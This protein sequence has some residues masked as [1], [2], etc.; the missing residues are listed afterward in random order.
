VG[1]A[2]IL[3]YAPGV[4][5]ETLTD[6]LAL[7]YQSNP[8]LL[9]QRA[10]L[11][12]TNENYVQAEAGF[13]PN[14][15]VQAT[16]TYNKAPFPQFPTAG[17]IEANYGTGVFSINQPIYT[18]GRVTAQVDTATAQIDAGREQL[19]ATE[20]TV[21]LAVIQAYCD[22]VRDR[23]SLA[24]QEKSFQSLL[25]TTLEIRAR[26][27]AGANTVTDRDQATTQL[28]S[29]KAMVDSARA[30]LESSVAEY[31][32]AVGQPPGTLALPKALLDVPL[33]IDSA[34]DAA[35][36]ESPTLRQAQYAEATSRAQLREAEAARRP[37]VTLSGT[38]GDEGPLS[39]VRTRDYFEDVGVTATLTQPVFT[40]GQIGSQVRQAEAQ[41]NAARIQVE[42]ARRNVMQAVAQAWAQRTATRANVLSAAAE[43]RAA[44]ATYDGM[45]VEYRAGLRITL[46]VLT[47]QETLRDSQIA[48]ATARHD[49]LLAEA[50]LLSAVGRLEA[51]MQIASETLYDPQKTF[52]NVQHSGA[53]PWDVLPRF[54]DKMGA[55]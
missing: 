16:A 8:T 24:I 11:E 52:E 33:D 27:E 34:F 10:Q 13:R 4:K 23:E 14:A 35:Q 5:A 3:V 1:F 44:Q 28:E 55:P 22:V 41:N 54:A 51:R 12:A 31:V 7:A 37:T 39:P 25:D 15:S 26:Y 36:K 53:V 50:N 32:N 29:S 38:Y 21:F 2:A 17:P 45:R 46:D 18:G 9:S 43:V 42:V 19:R 30:Q 6:A 40:G 49:A 20:Q 47:S 48:L